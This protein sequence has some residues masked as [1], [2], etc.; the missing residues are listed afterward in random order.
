MFKVP[1]K[2]EKWENFKAYASEQTCNSNINFENSIYGAYITLC[3]RNGKH[4]LWFLE[5]T[6]VI[7]CF[8][9]TLGQLQCIRILCETHFVIND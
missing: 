3:N 1:F 9:V 5:L 2:S 6:T 7:T 8:F 4:T